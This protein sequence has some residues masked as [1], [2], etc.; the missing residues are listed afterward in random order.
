M[1]GWGVKGEKDS[2]SETVEI[3]EA[4]GQSLE[5]IDSLFDIVRNMVYS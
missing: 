3:S 2:G 4:E 5:D 1:L